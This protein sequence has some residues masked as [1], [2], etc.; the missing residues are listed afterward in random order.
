MLC[1]LCL[2]GKVKLRRWLSD[3]VEDRLGGAEDGV[4]NADLSVVFGVRRRDIWRRPCDTGLRVVAYDQQVE[5]AGRKLLEG[6]PL[7]SK[8]P[9]A[10]FRLPPDS[11]ARDA[12]RSQAPELKS[13]A[14]PIVIQQRRR[15]D[16]G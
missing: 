4:I 13:N 7:E 15:H 6:L 9:L 5:I 11:G 14:R 12:S 16:Q 1:G 3:W 8:V 10:C 2:G